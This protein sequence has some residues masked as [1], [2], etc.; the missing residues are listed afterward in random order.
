MITS[1]IE[2]ITP[3]IATAMLAGNVENRK[4]KTAIVQQYA[5]DMKNARWKMNGAPIIFDCEGLLNDG[6]HR[7]MAVV[8]SGASVLMLVIRGVDRST[9]DTIDCNTVRGAGD[10]LQM[11]HILN[12][13]NVSSLARHLISYERTSRKVIGDKSNISKAQIIER[14]K[15][16]QRLQYAVR[17]AKKIN[18]VSRMAA[19]SF[20]IYV[21]ADS[22]KSDEFFCRIG[23]GIGLN[24][25]HPALTYRNWSIRNGKAVPMMQAIEALLRCWCAFRDG[26]QLSTVRLLGEL[27]A[28]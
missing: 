28:L 14:G 5:N 18:H 9:R 21:I 7:L 2:M 26:R 6:Q 15:V 19:T 11:F 16:D 12:G 25:G 4:P 1:A 24:N 10:V 22:P 23:D 17:E 8:E 3:E 27:P 13:N 20:A